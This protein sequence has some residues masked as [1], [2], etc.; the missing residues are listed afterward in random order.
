MLAQALDL[1]STDPSRFEAG[2]YLDLIALSHTVDGHSVKDLEEALLRNVI[3]LKVRG[4]S[5]GYL[6]YFC[7]HT[8]EAVLSFEYFEVL[9]DRRLCGV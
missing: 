7:I 4:S 9:S 6:S 1:L 2:F 3:G 5:N 8:R